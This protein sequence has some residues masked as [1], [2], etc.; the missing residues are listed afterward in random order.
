MTWNLICPGFKFLGKFSMFFTEYAISE[1][2]G[3]LIKILY[4][5]N[6]IFRYPSEGSFDQNY[7][8]YFSIGVPWFLIIKHYQFPT[9]YIDFDSLIFASGELKFVKSVAISSK[10]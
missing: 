9:I 5:K 8:T 7:K 4:L 3:I 10:K 1:Y 6:R 2:A